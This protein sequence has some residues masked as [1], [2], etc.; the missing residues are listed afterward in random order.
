M[1][2]GYTEGFYYKPRIDKELLAQHAKGLI[3]LS[4]C[5]KGEVAS[6]IR[7]G[8][9]RKALEAAAQLP[10]HSRRGQFLPR[11]AVSGDRRAAGR[12]QGPG[13]D[14]A[15]SGHAA[16]GHQRRALPDAW[17]PSSAR[18]PAL[19]RHGQDG[20]RSRS[21]A[22]SRR[23]VLFEDRRRDAEGVRRKCP[24]RWPTR[25]G[26]PSAA[27]SISPA[28]RT[29]CRT[30]PSPRR[31]RSTTT[32]STSCA[33]GSRSAWCGLQALQASGTLRHPI[34]EYENR[35]WYEIEMIK[36]MEYP[37][38]FLIVW[39]FIRY[40]REK[41]IPVGPGTRIGGRQPG[42]LLP[43]H[44]R[45]RSARLRPHLRALPEPRARVAA[46]HRHRLLRAAARRGHRVRHAEIRARERRAD[47]HVRDDEGARRRARRR[48]ARSTSRSPTSIGS[49]S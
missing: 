30:S 44:H 2:A 17:R 26:S 4:S 43:A 1:S 24:R 22:L 40:A 11:D 7:T 33:R 23:P 6:E 39:D 38:Y 36:R 10:R 42:R 5:L 8:R 47:H 29:T 32:S 48:A 49:R 18:H 25:C 3:G 31:T 28:T 15:R 46:R 13:A 37:G 16:G 27:R 34:E 9:E 12:Q 14:R 19:H 20:E 21:H 41:G 35:L 45:R